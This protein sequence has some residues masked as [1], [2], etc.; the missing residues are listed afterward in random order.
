MTSEFEW[1]C[2]F[3]CSQKKY[4]QTYFNR[5]RSW[6]CHQSLWYI[7]R[8][9]LLS[10]NLCQRE[11]LMFDSIH[12]YSPPTY[13]LSW[14]LI[15]SEY[16]K[17]RVLV[18]KIFRWKKPEMP[19]LKPHKFKSLVTR[20]PVNFGSKIV[21]AQWLISGDW[22]L[23]L[24]NGPKLAGGGGIEVL[25][26]AILHGQTR[27]YFRDEDILFKMKHQRHLY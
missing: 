5:S 2:H 20:L 24:V 11:Y 25:K 4:A 27:R 17:M 22:C 7:K 10:V 8:H 26:S 15:V 9:L 3:C 19:Q 14:F 18:C 13:P 21:K 23:P 1:Y 16:H 12:G 6:R